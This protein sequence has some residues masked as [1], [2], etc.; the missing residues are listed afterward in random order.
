MQKPRKRKQLALQQ[1]QPESA[2][3]P[4]KLATGINGVTK[5][6]YPFHPRPTPDECRAVRDGLLALHGFPREFA[7]YRE[8]RRSN[9][10][11]PDDDSPCIDSVEATHVAESEPL[12][13]NIRDGGYDANESV[14]DGLVRTVLSQNTTEVNSQ[15]AFASLKSA[16]P[17]WEDVCFPPCYYIGCYG[18][19]GIF[20]CPSMILDSKFGVFRYC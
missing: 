6:P 13:A 11:Y 8:R 10:L 20:G 2:T 17:T 3:K 12:D 1:D 15:R 9:G 4:A 18:L 7:E 19:I 16:F 14:L 5:D